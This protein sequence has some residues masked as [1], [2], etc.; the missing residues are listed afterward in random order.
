MSTAASS[1]ENDA[2]ER[3][4]QIIN[5][6]S[7]TMRYLALSNLAEVEICE[8]PD[9]RKIGVFADAPPATDRLRNLFRSA[10]AVD[11]YNGERTEPPSE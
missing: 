3:R 4:A 8:Y 11:Y 10:S 6:G 9:S 2:A 5:T 1:A 7:V